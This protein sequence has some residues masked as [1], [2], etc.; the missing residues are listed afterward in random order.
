MSGSPVLEVRG[1]LVPLLFLNDVLGGERPGDEVG[2]NVMVLDAQGR[3]FGLVVDEVLD[4]EE[5]VVKPL[6]RWLQSARVYSGVTMLG[7][8]LPA[9]I[10]DVLELSSRTV[11]LAN[12]TTGHDGDVVA[13]A[14]G[15]RLLIAEVGQ[16]RRVVIPLESVSRLAE[17][18]GSS[19]EWVGTREVIQHGGRIL[20]LVRLAG[21]IGADL[22]TRPTYDAAERCVADTNA[23]ALGRQGGDG[24]E[25]GS[26]DQ[27][28]D[29]TIL[30]V[31]HTRAG[32]SVA[33][34]VES[35]V[36]IVQERVERQD[37]EDS[38]LTGS[39]IIDDRV[40]ELLDVRRAILAADPSFYLSDDERAATAADPDHLVG[41]DQ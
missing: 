16:G 40:S 14:S 9:P 38:G 3:R 27:A 37:V 4:S 12:A 36:D 33:L 35:V 6:S 34:Q 8:G 31:V 20:P 39:A 17:Y 41:A 5:I 15:D 1:Q 7:D 10:L 22:G 11:H 13:V 29:D 18:P 30:V 23:E 25:S 21:H 24:D 32:R 19:V 28:G 26:E 2:L